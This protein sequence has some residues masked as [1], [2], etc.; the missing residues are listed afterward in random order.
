MISTP[1][2]VIDIFLQPGEHYFGDKDI[3]IRTLLGSCVSITMWHPKLLVG[4]M[5]HYM[6]PTRA[7]HTSTLNGKYADEALQLLI[8]EAKQI[9][10]EP[11]EY[12]IKLFGGGNMFP[13]AKKQQLVHVGLKNIE[14]ARAL[15]KQRKL[16]ISAE[17]LGGAGHRNLMFEVWSGDVWMQHNTSTNTQAHTASEKCETGNICQVDA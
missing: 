12:K 4:G 11:S 14:A 17:H 3:R 2:H 10:T 9:G 13:N 1:P 7:H 16:V 15:L 5:C 8:N 6:L